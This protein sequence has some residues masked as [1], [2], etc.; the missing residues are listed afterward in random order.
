MWFLISWGLLLFSFLGGEANCSCFR[1]FRIKSD[2]FWIIYWLIDFTYCCFVPF[3]TFRFLCTSIFCCHGNLT[4]TLECFMKLSSLRPCSH[5]TFAST[6][7]ST[8]T[9]T[10]CTWWH[11][12]QPIPRVW[13]TIDTMQNLTQTSKTLLHIRS[14]S[15]FLW[16]APL[17]FLTFCV[18][19]TK[20]LHGTYFEQ[21][22]NRLLR[23][24]V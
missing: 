18:N 4:L 6:L 7:T 17:I 5:I 9:L 3:Y 19:S 8:S 13:V 21:Y 23:R 12:R 20:G 15:P 11:K 2:W 10:L 24:Y 1:T 16:A 22:E 14:T